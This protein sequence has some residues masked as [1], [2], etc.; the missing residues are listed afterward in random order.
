MT[1]ID[2]DTSENQ[3]SETL[4]KTG[5]VATLCFARAKGLIC[6][7]VRRVDPSFRKHLRE[8]TLLGVTH[9]SNRIS[10]RHDALATA[11]RVVIFVHGYGGH[12]GNFL[13]L[14]SYFHWRGHTATL[15]VGFSDHRTIDSMAEELRTTIWRLIESSPERQAPWIDLV[16]HSM[17]GILCRVVLDDP[18][19]A[20]HISNLITL[21]TP[22][23]GT[24]LARFLDTEKT[25][26][27]RPNS[28]LLQRLEQQVPW[29]QKTGW[30]RL[31]CFWTPDDLI[32]LPP[33]TATVAG[34]VQRSMPGMTHLSFL[35]DPVA[36]KEIYDALAPRCARKL[37]TADAK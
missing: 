36:W 6:N 15:A 29:R 19:L 20:G 24:E 37:L 30:P 13:P 22:H 21:A 32:L 9:L 35:V 8:A 27:L 11:E 14:R 26:Q 5:R 3:W 17:G 10:R 4:R 31:T 23:A 7:T 1:E 34:A 2:R 16:G 33:T 12:R 25:R 18:K 28:E